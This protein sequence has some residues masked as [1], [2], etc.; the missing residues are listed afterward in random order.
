MTD[1]MADVSHTPPEGDDV[2]NV[3]ERGA[4]AEE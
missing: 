4:E 2:A 1:E 3:W